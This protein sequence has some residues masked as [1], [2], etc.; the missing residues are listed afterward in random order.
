[1]LSKSS[2]LIAFI[3][4]L[5]SSNL[6]NLILVPA[7]VKPVYL[8]DF[9]NSLIVKPGVPPKSSSLRTISVSLF[10]WILRISFSI[11]CLASFGL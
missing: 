7:F 6:S 11:I 10:F 1:M 8:S 9:T 5:N 3:A 2:C 4:V